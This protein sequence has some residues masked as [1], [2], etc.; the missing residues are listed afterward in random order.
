[1]TLV[2]AELDT[3]L[4][5]P[6]VSADP[7][8]AADVRAAAAWVAERVEAAGGTA[9][10]V[11]TPRHPLVVGRVEAS[12]GGSAPE[13]LVY[14][15]VDVQPPA[16]LEEWESRPFEPAVRDGWLYARGVADMK[17]QLHMVLEAIGEL[18]HERALPVRVTVLCDGEEEIGGTSV[19]DH[20]A[21]V[22]TPYDAA[23]IYDGRL[24]RPGVPAFVV[25]TRG[26][27]GYDV[28]LRTGARDLHSGLYG[29]AAL[30]AVHAL[31]DTLA[32]LLPR[33]GRLPAP[34]R[35]S[36][37]PVDPRIASVWHELTPGPEAI[38]RAGAVPYDEAAEREFYLR[39][40]A[41][42][43]VDVNGILGGKPGLTNTTVPVVATANFT[44]RLGPGQRVDE[45][46]EAVRALLHESAPR[47]AQLELTP[48]TGAPPA[49]VDPDA[50]ALRLAEDA[51]ERVLGVRPRLVP[52]GG[53]MPILATLVS[54]GTPV[55]LTGFATND[56]NI[57]S[58]NERLPLENLDLG[59]RAAR[60]LLLAFGAL[61]P[62]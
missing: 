5:I 18:A 43:S 26:A 16:P 31:I 14:G 44:V 30:N 59:R 7:T 62:R 11:E 60:E 38:A 6:S 51:F 32:A 25:R 34:L 24:I 39:T 27:L 54:R 53:T 49:A 57:H 58:P 47:G 17:G 19:V 61:R 4:R 3:F 50:P 13:V 21:G 12:G 48:T 35:A 37:E 8:H 28:R 23:I 42:P 40:T 56:S 29:N 15:H 1:V 46:D 45:I 36:L 2:P 55:V 10:L 9:E 52:V 22:E 33:D 20:L 41:E